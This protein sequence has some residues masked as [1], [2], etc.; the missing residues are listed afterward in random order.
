MEAGALTAVGS[1]E[2]V[3]PESDLKQAQERIRR[4][5]R[6]LAGPLLVSKCLN[7]QISL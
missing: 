2:R 4:L 1:E 3:A 5:E 6:L 7:Q